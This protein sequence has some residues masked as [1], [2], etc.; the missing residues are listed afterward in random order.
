MYDRRGPS[1]QGSQSQ[2][3][4]QSHQKGWNKKKGTSKKA[5]HPLEM[6]SD[7]EDAASEF[8]ALKLET[9]TFHRDLTFDSLT[10]DVRDEVFAT[11]AVDIPNR[12]GDHTLKVKVDTGAQGNILPTRIFKQIQPKWADGDDTPHEP[13]ISR[14]STRLLAYNGAEIPQHGTVNLSCKYKNGKWHNDYYQYALAQMSA[15]ACLSD[16]DVK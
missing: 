12:R 3:K 16:S 8:N 7:D 6:T 11:L 9:L 14:S 4:S 1:N 10:A 13:L 15:S 5:V 2:Q